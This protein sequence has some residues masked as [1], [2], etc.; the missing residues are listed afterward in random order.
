M[1]S[2][3]YV[4][5]QALDREIFVDRANRLALRFD[6]HGIRRAVRNGAA[7]S[8]RCQFRAAAPAQPVI[9]LIAMQQRAAAAPRGCNAF[10][11][12]RRRL[13]RNRSRDRSRYGYAVRI[14][15]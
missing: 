15:S 14:R 1:P 11:Q 5:R 2:K 12:H 9:H 8:D 4:A 10:R 7:R 6:N 3:K 13:L